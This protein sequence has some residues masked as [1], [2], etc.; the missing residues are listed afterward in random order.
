MVRLLFLLVMLS[1]SEVIEENLIDITSFSLGGWGYGL[2]V[3]LVMF[4]YSI[5][6][7]LLY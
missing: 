4:K 7:E 5:K 2:L 3:I 1:D 6:I